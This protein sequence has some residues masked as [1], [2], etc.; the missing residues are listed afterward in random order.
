MRICFVL[1]SKN[2]EKNAA[3][4]SKIS[5]KFI[6]NNELIQPEYVESIFALKDQVVSSGSRFEKIIALVMTENLPDMEEVSDAITEIASVLGPTQSIVVCDEKDILVP[7]LSEAM[8]DYSDTLKYA[9]IAKKTPT[10]IYNAVF[11]VDNK[12]ASKNII[13]EVN[14]AIRAENSKPVQPAP[15]ADAPI[16]ITDDA[17]IPVSDDT[18]IAVTDDAVMPAP[19]SEDAVMPA[20]IADDV[21]EPVAENKKAKKGKFGLPWK[22]KTKDKLEKAAK[23]IEPAPI[24][25]PVPELDV[26]PAPIPV[27]VPAPTAED[28]PK[29]KPLRKL[30]PVS[31]TKETEEEATT[32]IAPVVAETPVVESAVEEEEDTPPVFIDDSMFTTDVPVAPTATAV[33]NNDDSEQDDEVTP[34]LPEEPVTKKGFGRKVKLNVPKISKEHLSMQ[35]RPRLI[36]VT[37]TGRIGQSTIT[38]S[39]GFTAAQFFCRSLIVDLD[40]IKRAISCIYPDYTNINSQQSS[41]LV[42]AIR[43]PHLIDQIAQEH[44]DRVSTLGISISAADNR[45]ILKS[46]SALDIQTLLLQALQKFN[47]VVVDM[48]WSYLTENPQLLGLPHDI[49]FC[50]SNDIMTMIS[51][52]NVLTEDAFARPEDFQMLIAKMKFVLNMTSAE[53]M[54]ENKHITEKNFN[55]ICYQIT[56]EDMFKTIPVLSNIPMLPNI[57]NQVAVGR[58]ASSFSKEFEA[59]CSQI[60]HALN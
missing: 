35:T 28:T 18:P 27:P 23:G 19:V 44:Y 6:S 31:K 43:S 10:A 48:P 2:S 5:E 34:V 52:L 8:V 47:V 56:E 59:Y 60:L 22:K 1:L 57:G 49:L 25:V 46:I 45:K 29:P 4:Y 53:N 55:K 50:T 30:V 17:P 14:T 24:P 39:L 32:D 16:P 37:G 7:Y 36:F 3:N 11:G 42:A 12:T 20:P 15:V 51:D 9:K 40:M 41:G 58:P 21:T 26:E 13:N 38:G 54:Y 33:N